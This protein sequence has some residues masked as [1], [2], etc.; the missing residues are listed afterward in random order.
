[1]RSLYEGAARIGIAPFDTRLHAAAALL[2]VLER[3]ICNLQSHQG[4][5]TSGTGVK[6]YPPSNVPNERQR[7]APQQKA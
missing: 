3:A 1:M 7:A 5:I 2:R 6:I 4:H